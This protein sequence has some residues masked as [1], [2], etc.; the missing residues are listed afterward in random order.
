MAVLGLISDIPV[1]EMVFLMLLLFLTLN[2]LKKL[3]KAEKTVGIIEK[4]L[5]VFFW[6]GIVDIF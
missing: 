3:I 1:K 5:N 2:H 4:S 6:R